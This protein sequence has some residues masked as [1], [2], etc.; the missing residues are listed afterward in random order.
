MPADGNDLEVLLATRH[1]DGR[2]SWTS[3]RASDMVL[4]VCLA[5][6]WDA[7]EHARQVSCLL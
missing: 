3:G 5:L 1:L 4:G 2:Q 6:V 7:A